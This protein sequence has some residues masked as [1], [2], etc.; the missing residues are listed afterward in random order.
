MSEICLKR[1]S[2]IMVKNSLDKN[3]M[4]VLN[5]MIKSVL[6]GKNTIDVNSICKTFGFD[7]KNVKKIIASL[8][9]LKITKFKKA[10]DIHEVYTP[11]YHVLFSDG[12]AQFW[13]AEPFLKILKEKERYTLIDLKIQRLL[14]SKYA[15]IFY[16]IASL[17]FNEKKGV[18]YTEKYSIENFKTLLGLEDSDYPDYRFFKR[19]II[20]K[21]IKNLE[22]YT[23][24]VLTIKEIKKGPK[25]QQ[26]YFEIRKKDNLTASSD[27]EVNENI[28][29]NSI[30]KT[31]NEISNVEFFDGEYSENQLL[32]AKKKLESAKEKSVIKDEQKYLNTI[33]KNSQDDSQ[34]TITPEEIKALK[35]RYL[36]SVNPTGGNQYHVGMEDTHKYFDSYHLNES[37]VK[38]KEFKKYQ[39]VTLGNINIFTNVD[40]NKCNL[41]W[42]EYKNHYQDK[43]DFLEKITNVN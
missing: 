24:F 43:L 32:Q 10:N 38:M 5:L 33:L 27:T 37:I 2:L 29:T 3:Q 34:L 13:C 18:G 11:I 4:F 26:L 19:N 36:L 8:V 17:C 14:P 23:D 6:N 7:C 21:N 40:A 1:E 12:I 30:S 31:T 42:N 15:Y 25:V 20:N 39:N 41:K 35:F 22:K 28:N 16:E 9:D